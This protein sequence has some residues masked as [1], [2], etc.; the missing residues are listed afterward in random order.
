MPSLAARA[1]RIR[2]GLFRRPAPADIAIDW[3]SVAASLRSLKFPRIA[4]NVRR[5]S[6]ALCIHGRDDASKAR[7]SEFQWTFYKHR[8]WDKFHTITNGFHSVRTVDRER[9]RRFC[10][11][12]VPRNESTGILSRNKTAPFVNNGQSI[13]RYYVYCSSSVTRCQPRYL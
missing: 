6:A 12:P 10:S 1:A 11:L 3:R 2:G 4:E 5:Y 7:F 13:P 9:V 8:P